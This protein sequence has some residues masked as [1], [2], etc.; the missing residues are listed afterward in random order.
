MAIPTSE[1]TAVPAIAP[2]DRPDGGD[3]DAGDGVGVEVIVLTP[4]G[5]GLKAELLLLPISP[6]AEDDAVGDGDDVGVVVA[7]CTRVTLLLVLLVV[8]QDAVDATVTPTERHCCHGGQIAHRWT[9][10]WCYTGDVP[11]IIE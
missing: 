10:S 4:V 2:A 5:P 6:A 9:R 1:P 7:D 3:D 8:V 11:T